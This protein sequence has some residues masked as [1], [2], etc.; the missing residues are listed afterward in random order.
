LF[1]DCIERGKGFAKRATF[2]DMLFGVTMGRDEG[3]GAFLVRIVL[4]FV[5]NVTMG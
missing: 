1:W 2:W 3:M 4:N 5:I